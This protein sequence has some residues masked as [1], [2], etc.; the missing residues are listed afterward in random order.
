MYMR[1]A[2]A[3]LA[4]AAVWLLFAS[5]PLLALNPALAVSQY[6]HTAWTVRDGF[7]LGN[8]YAMAQTPDGYLW[9]GTEFGLFRFDGV[10]FLPW[11]P[12]A[13]QQL[14][15]KNINSLLV[16]R[17]GSLWIGTFAGLVILRDGSLARPP[18][19][20]DQFVA[21][22]F[23]DGE[24]TVWA[25]SLNRAGQLCAIRSG[26]AKCSGEDGAFGRAVW[27]TYEDGSGTLWAAAES[28]VWRLRPGP[29][30]RYGAR[31]E[32]IGLNRTEDGRLLM[33]LHGAGLMQLAGDEVEA[34]PIR[35]AVNR[36]RLLADHEVNANRLL[37]DRDGGLWIGTVDRGLI[38]LR[39]GRADLFRRSDGLSGDVILSL[40]EDREGTVW[41]AS[42]GGLD[43]F[44]E[45][46]VTTISLR[47]GLS[48]EAT[49]AVLAATDGS[50]WAG[51]VN[52]LTRL[53]NGETTIFR[54]GRGVPDAPQS[55]YQDDRGRIW[56][57]TRQGLAYFAD[58]TFVG[59]KGVPGG[60]VHYIAGD[61]EGN[62]WLSEQENLL[63]L[64]NGRL[65]EQ[66]PWS[67]LGRQQRASTL[68]AE[69]GGVWLGF[70]ADGAVSYLKDRQLRASYTAADGLG[71]P[72]VQH[73]QLDRDGGLWAATL[74]GGLSRIKDGHVATLT[75]RNGLPCDGTNW[76]ID[77]DEGSL[78][79][80][81]RCGLVRITRTEVDA[82]IADS[83][84]RIG[85]TVW[86]S[87]D[88]VRLR[89]S[90][91]SEYAPRVAKSADGKLWFV[92]GEGI[93]V[94]DPRHLVVNEIPPPVRIEQV[95][96]DRKTYDTAR[97]VRLP[98]LVRDLQLDFT[99]LSLAAPEK[100]R[101]RY[102]LEGYDNDWQ[103]AGNRRQAFY[104]NLPSRSYR[105]RVIAANNS[106]VWNE[107]GDVLE[108]SIAP[109]YYQTAWFGAL[110]VAGALGLLWAG[111]RIRVRQ[112]HHRFDMALEA[113]VSERTR[114]A[115][116]LHDTLLQ[117]FHGLLL[118]FQ[119]V[120]QL[121]AERPELAKEK[122]DGAITEAARAITEGRNAVQGLRESA[123]GTSD[124][125]DAIKTLG[126][127]LVAARGDRQAPAF[128]VTVEG[129]P[130][131]LH[132]ILR[133]D[134]YKITT[135]ALRNAFWHADATDVEVEIR[136]DRQQF[137]LRVQDDGKGFDEAL[138]PRQAAAGHYGVPGMRERAALMGGTL[139][140]WSKV[141]A[142]T[143]VE[144]CIPSRSA[145]VKTRERGWLSRAFTGE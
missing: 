58:D 78:W 104:T 12:P 98:P 100:V 47:Q 2:L 51:A 83:K 39:D 127:E 7:S 143:A 11:Q 79:L 80:Y 101:F 61:S 138:L 49:Q 93:Q 129:E 59:V 38:H 62:L 73:L 111:Y 52:G 3:L 137:R 120:S 66:I 29:P 33:A 134:I 31:T 109:A 92:T 16:T 14:P 18:V 91:A 64:M 139:T 20:H 55:L 141:G 95:T 108:F 69:R 13:G 123:V 96:A 106:G 133:D 88:G 10:R 35:D 53:K 26:G 82:W 144:L 113:R 103:E 25:A 125:A 17:D 56:V 6:A 126:A 99:A 75:S 57:S 112:L 4:I 45:L 36:N 118:R 68:L 128:H 1:R 67:E 54:T 140:V 32:L 77:D 30:Q 65:V 24:G 114:I 135:E 84:H 34:Y 74:N 105:F 63:H 121:W 71:Q 89:S 122:L 46:P 117:S 44:R 115:R 145:Y 97:D 76:T 90:A 9:L 72:P 60:V 136:Y 70:W 119:T 130:R 43:R 81:M 86:D 124:I 116:E 15:D 110:C 131:A 22:L 42:T 132:P 107:Q 28:G 21:S 102:K 48:S 8:V 41:V 142:G 27:A 87:A 40:F 37:R 23:E 19:L 50:I 85:T 5:A 94:V